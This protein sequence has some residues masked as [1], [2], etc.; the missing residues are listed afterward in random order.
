MTLIL[1]HATILFSSG[2]TQDS[3]LRQAQLE[4]IQFG[5]SSGA[6]QFPASFQNYSDAEFIHFILKTTASLKNK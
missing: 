1:K 3:A 6:A 4:Y 2:S 5:L